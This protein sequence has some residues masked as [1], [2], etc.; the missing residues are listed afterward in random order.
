MFLFLKSAFI[1]ILLTAQCEPPPCLRG[2]FV[3][4]SSAKGCAGTEK[5][6]FR[7]EA[8]SR[9]SSFESFPSFFVFTREERRGDDGGCRGCASRICGSKYKDYLAC[10]GRRR[11]RRCRCPTT[12]GRLPRRGGRRVSD[13]RLSAFGQLPAE[14]RTV[15]AAFLSGKSPWWP[16]SPSFASSRVGTPVTCLLSSSLRVVVPPS[17]PPYG[18]QWYSSPNI[19]SKIN[20]ASAVHRQ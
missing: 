16:L 5:R 18:T 15:R 12:G 19:L 2:S 10:S 8:D 9:E 13:R 4:D 11:W 7:M 17:C 3:D 6:I 1:L 20:V 14:R